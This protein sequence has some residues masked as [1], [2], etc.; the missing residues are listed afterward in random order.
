MLFRSSIGNGLGDWQTVASPFLG[1]T[2]G[3][4]VF[5]APDYPSATDSLTN[6]GQTVPFVT[7][8]RAILEVTKNIIQDTIS[9][10]SLGNNRYLIVLAPGTHC[11]VNDPGTTVNDFTVDFTSPFTEVTQNFLSQFNPAG[12]GGLILPRGVS[13]IG[14]DLKKCSV[15][16]THVPLYTHP[17]FPPDYQLQ[18]DGPVYQSQPLSSVFRWSGNTY[19]S[20]FTALDKIETRLVT[21]VVKQSK[22]NYAVF[23]SETP[24]G[25]AFNDFV[26][27]SY[28]D[29]TDQAGASFNSGAYY[30]Y[31]INAY[32]FL[33]SATSWESLTV[34]PVLASAL[35]VSYF[36]SQASPE[37]G[38]AHV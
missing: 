1:G 11:V 26:Q 4:T 19:V 6:D 15:H 36:S 5:V 2:N 33:I 13:I 10:I 38:R 30:A 21:Q 27:I 31:P 35:P 18:L 32:N 37:I 7:I 12:V 20:N 14:L 22:T 8:N 29:S 3:Y 9:G 24:H 34:T 17:S 23:T 28:S 25:L 16:P